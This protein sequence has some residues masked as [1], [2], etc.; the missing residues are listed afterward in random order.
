MGLEL[1]LM[2][3]SILALSVRDME[4]IWGLSKLLLGSFSSFSRPV[5]IVG[6][7]ER[8]LRKSALFVKARGFI[9]TWRLLVLGFPGALRM[10]RES[11]CL[12]RGLIMWI[13]WPR[14]WFLW[15]GE[16]SMS[17]IRLEGILILR[18]RLV[19]LL[20]RLFWALVGKLG[21]WTEVLL[22]SRGLGLLS[23]IRRLFFR[24]RDC[25]SIRLVVIGGILGW[26]VGW[27]CLGVCL[28]RLLI[29]LEL[30]LGRINKFKI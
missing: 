28:R 25:L 6:G 5:R 15:S 18:L 16:F 12:A 30:S 14:I 20:G 8:L 21:G 17:F 4:S 10:E 22:V 7:R 2:T 9:M 23:R 29:G 11:S 26:C 1:T 19:F 13:S 24:A 27:G 3:L